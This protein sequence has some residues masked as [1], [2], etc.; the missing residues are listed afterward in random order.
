MSDTCLR[1]FG[2]A[3][4]LARALLA[5]TAL[6]LAPAAG[7]SATYDF[8]LLN[9]GST[10]WQSFVI[11]GPA[12]TT[13]VG[14]ATVGEITARC[15]AGQPDGFANEIECGPLSGSGVAPGARVVFAGTLSTGSGCGA[16][17]QLEVSPTGAAPFAAAG[18]ATPVAGCAASPPGALAPPGIRGTARVGR[19]LT[20]A[21]A[22]WTAAPSH[23][24]YQWQRCADSR[25]RTISTKRTL[26][27][28]R[29][30][31]GR[32]VR[33]VAVATIGGSEVTSVSKPVAVRR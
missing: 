29:A 9:G 18:D 11:V 14:G 3:R 32:T 16:T 30:D 1:Q 24:A 20:V 28:T 2:A 27:L 12:G 13:F 5:V 22:T 21:A 6:A 19:T 10:A 31:A 8:V 7:A 4:A 17:F 15:V 25:C 33:V 26:V 23:V